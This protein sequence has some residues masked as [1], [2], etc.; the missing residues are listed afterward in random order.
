MN[1]LDPIFK[2]RSIVVYGVSRDADKMGSIIYGNLKSYTD[3]LYIVHPGTEEIN[4]ERCYKS[5]VDIPDEI[6]LA[7]IALPAKYTV[8]A[9]RDCA[10]KGVRS[11]IPIAG[12]FKEAGG[13]GANLEEELREVIKSSGM[14]V[15]GPNTVGIYMPHSGLNTL[16]LPK[17][18]IGMA[19]PGHIAL[20]SQSG[21][22]ASAFMD[23]ACAHDLGLSAFVGFGNRA[24]VNENE[25]V[26]YFA[27]DPDTRTIIVYLESF[28]NGREFIEICREVNKKKPVVVLKA[29]RTKSGARAA[30][31]HTGSLSASDVVTKGALK[32]AGITRAL[33][34]HELLDDGIVLTYNRPICGRR[35]G[36]VT[37]AGG[38]GVIA[39]DYIESKEAGFDLEMAVFGKETM[40][41]LKEALPPFASVGNPI[42]LTAAADD[43]MYD[44]TIECLQES[45]EVDAILVFALFQSPYVSG[46]TVD[47]IKKWY[48]NG[49]KPMVI[50]CIGG[51][52]TKFYIDQLHRKGVTTYSSTIRAL[53]AIRTLVDRG[54]FLKREG[55]V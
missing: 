10:A 43:A 15:I 44:K 48:D 5:A 27:E 8:G 25:L 18:R 37:T 33:D 42:D 35:I 51:D 16:F 13:D 30:A 41:R 53:A 45:E 24:D 22:M 46:A 47:V 29:G 7:I 20:I 50:C 55:I 14:R 9:M 52:Y 4:G 12:G 26:R 19:K 40:A 34:E 28:S 11:A 32:Q 39:A 23:M 49:K 1:G 21:F 38:A 36:V 54:T 6:D 3:R 2:P 31:S 17:D